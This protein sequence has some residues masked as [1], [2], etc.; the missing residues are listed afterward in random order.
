MF[1]TLKRKLNFLQTHA[2]IVCTTF[3]DETYVEIDE[4]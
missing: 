1:G 2:D 3:S 4:T